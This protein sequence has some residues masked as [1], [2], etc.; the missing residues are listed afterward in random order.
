MRYAA[1][2]SLTQLRE[3]LKKLYRYWSYFLIFVEE[4]RNDSFPFV[5]APA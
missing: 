3:R 4:W 1:R 2:Y 5:V